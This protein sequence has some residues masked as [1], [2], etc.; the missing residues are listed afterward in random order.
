MTK[1]GGLA[2]VLA[3]VDADHR[4]LMR[5][6][7]QRV[8]ATLQALEAGGDVVVLAGHATTAVAAA[9]ALGI[10]TGAIASSLIFRAYRADGTVDPLL[11]MTSG[12]H[13]VD[14]DKVRDTLGLAQLE[15]ADARYVREQ[16]G[17]AIGGVAPVGHPSQ[18]ATLV[19]IAL[20][21]YTTVWAAAGHPR[22]VFPTSYDELL[23]I[24]GGQSVEVT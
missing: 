23:R 17:F 7:V 8:V 6:S 15:R 19:D 4:V 20:G 21:R 12:A 10:E 3:M 11:V 9:A 22:V 14:T 24:T 13:R 16:T 5:E 1:A 18:P 2:T